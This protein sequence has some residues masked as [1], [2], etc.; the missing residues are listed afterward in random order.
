MRTILFF[1]LLICC[2]PSMGQCYL[3]FV[4][5]ADS[6]IAV[7]IKRLDFVT[8]IPAHQTT[9]YFKFPTLLSKEV[10][11]LTVD[12]KNYSYI[13]DRDRRKPLPPGHYEMRLWFNGL[14]GY[15]QEIVKV[16]K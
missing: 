14:Q 13:A 11:M 2:R 6:S 4:N 10:E 5:D 16:I 3:R 7:S 15:Q 1:L 9:H 8:V 12:G